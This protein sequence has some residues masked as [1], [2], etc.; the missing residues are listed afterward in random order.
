MLYD[1]LMFLRQEQFEERP[2]LY[3]QASIVCPFSIIYHE[4]FCY[5]LYDLFLFNTPSE[6]YP[7]IWAI[8]FCFFFMSTT[9]VQ[10][11][12]IFVEHLLYQ[13]VYRNPMYFDLVCE[14]QKSTTIWI[15]LSLFASYS[16][17]SNLRARPLGSS[18]I[19]WSSLHVHLRHFKYKWPGFWSDLDMTKTMDRSHS[20]LNFSGA[21]LV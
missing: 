5:Q 11:E 1:L 6:M 7:W 8:R 9:A 20:H 14:Q 17:I 15:H 21:I 4:L 3:V 12:E 16:G 2:T 13:T 18:F 10:R 19:H